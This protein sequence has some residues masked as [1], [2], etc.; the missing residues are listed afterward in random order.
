MKSLLVDG[1]AVL[2]GSKN[3]KTHPTKSTNFKPRSS[4]TFLRYRAPLV[5]FFDHGPS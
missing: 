5:T 4:P 2:L 3:S 1:S